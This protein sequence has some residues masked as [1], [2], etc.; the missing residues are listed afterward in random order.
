MYIESTYAHMCIELLIST[1]VHVYIYI[2]IRYTHDW[3][4][5]LWPTGPIWH[6]NAWRAM[7]IP[8]PTLAGL[9]TVLSIP[10]NTEP[11]T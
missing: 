5:H 7:C 11:K 3:D 10:G 6:C 1:G 9:G 8:K 4:I 2:C